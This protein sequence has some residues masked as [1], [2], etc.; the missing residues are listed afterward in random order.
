MFS[1]CLR[2][3]SK[4][5]SATQQQNSCKVLLETECVPLLF[6]KTEN[7]KNQ[8][9]SKR[10]L[11]SIGDEILYILLV[12]EN[13]GLSAILLV[14]G[15]CCLASPFLCF[16]L[17]PFK[18]I[19]LVHFKLG[20][21]SP[22][23]LCISFGGFQVHSAPFCLCAL[24]WCLSSLFCLC[25]SNW[26]LSSPFCLCVCASNW[27]L[28]SPFCLCASNWCLSSPFCLCASNWC[29]SSPFCLC[30][31]KLVPFKSILLV[32]FKFVPF[33]SILLVFQIGAFQVH[34]ACVL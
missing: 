20:L 14:C 21:S 12:C 27:C 19:L 2:H 1:T 31:L 34:S 11:G 16:K 7:K 18:S 17:V 29:L 33:K 8:P 30:A 5:A 9:P 10:R 6:V 3:A 22:F 26:C 13:W 23:W 15:N 24:N 25:T 28:S 4:H 32:C